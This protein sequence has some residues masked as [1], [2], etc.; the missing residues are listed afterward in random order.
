MVVTVALK[1]IHLRLA[2]FAVFLRL[3]LLA[4]LRVVLL[5][6]LR[7][8]VVPRLALLVLLRLV[9]LVLLRFA[10]DFPWGLTRSGSFA[11][12]VSRFHSSNV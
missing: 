7:L 11:D 8:L 10:A 9:L 1:S 4:A 12:P 3:D 2:F 5:V 6:V